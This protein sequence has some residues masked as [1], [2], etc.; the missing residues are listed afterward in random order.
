MAL[1]PHG[2]RESS[3]ESHTSIPSHGSK[4]AGSKRSVE[5]WVVSRES[6]QEEV[7]ERLATSRYQLYELGGLDDHQVTDFIVGDNTIQL[8]IAYLEEKLDLVVKAFIL[9][10]DL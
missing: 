5:S 4:G 8:V 10:S 3:D 9:L 6:C 2:T 1:N 7:G